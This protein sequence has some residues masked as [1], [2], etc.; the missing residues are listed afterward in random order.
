MSNVHGLVEGD[1]PPSVRCAVCHHALNMRDRGGVEE[2]YHGP[3]PDHIP[4]HTIVPEPIADDHEALAVCDFCSYPIEPGSEWDVP[5]VSFSY[6]P[7][8]DVQP[9]NSLGHW[10]ICLRCV[11][12]YNAR[13]WENMAKRSRTAR[14]QPTRAERRRAISWMTGLWTALVDNY[15]LGPPRPY[16]RPVAQDGQARRPFQLPNLN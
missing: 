7:T 12:D 8:P 5:A 16:F 9:T 4:E 15:A 13:D 10:A 14:E 2:Y 3:L 11:T 6:A 1:E